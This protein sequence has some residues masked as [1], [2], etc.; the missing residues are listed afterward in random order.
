VQT[1]FSGF[2]IVLMISCAF[3]VERS[4]DLL[5]AVVVFAAYSLLMAVNW[6]LLGAPD[7][8]ITEAAVGAGVT[9]LL[10]VNAV[11]RTRRREE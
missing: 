4:R 11:R 2:V 6:Q 3:A 1:V 8:A 9:T 7:V 5:A 10:L